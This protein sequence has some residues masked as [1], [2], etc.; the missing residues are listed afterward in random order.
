M[1]PV[2]EIRGEKSNKL[3]NRRIALCLTGSI[4][5]VES[6]YLCRELIKHGA[7]VVPVMS[8]AATRI[9]HPDTMEFASG[10]KPILSLTGEVE[11]VSLCGKDKEV[12]LILVSPCTANTLSKIVLGISDNPVTACVVTGEKAGIPIMI[13]PAMHLSMYK[14]PAIVKH[15]KEAKRRFDVVEPSIKDD[16][17]RIAGVDEIVGRVKRIL[18]NNDLAGKNILIIGGASVEAV[19]DIRIITNR[20]SGKMS[21]ALAV[22]AFERGADVKLW[23]GRVSENVPTYIKTKEFESVNDL[24]KMINSASLERFNVVIVCAALANYIPKKHNGKIPSDKEDLRIELTKAPYIISNI[25]KKNRKAR[26]V[27]FKAEERSRD[28]ERR[29]MEFMNKNGV[30]MVVANTLSAF[31]TDDSEIWIVGK[32]RKILHIKGNKRSLAEKIIT[33]VKSL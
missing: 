19:D 17:L 11:H 6:F 7:D 29:A 20:S 26:I 3:K 1:H 32:D 33:S 25:R 9:I 14:N 16:R 12:D 4:A 23:H 15:L 30:D 28:I 18:G 21:I 24:L 10:N 5:A 13:V 31:G 22:D 8:E 2:E 27:A